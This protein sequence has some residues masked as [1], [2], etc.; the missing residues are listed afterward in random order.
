MLKHTSK[1]AGSRAAALAIAM[2]GVGCTAL[3]G[4]GPATTACGPE[5]SSPAHAAAS[6]SVQNG[7]MQKLA[8]VDEMTK[9]TLVEERHFDIYKRFRALSAARGRMQVS[10]G[11]DGRGRGNAGMPAAN[12]NNGDSPKHCSIR[13][14]NTAD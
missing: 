7:D 3:G 12:G 11:T 2:A 6:A 14:L 10:G 4:A 1:R 8:V 5:D 9:P 13:D